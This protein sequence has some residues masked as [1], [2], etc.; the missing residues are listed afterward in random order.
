MGC[1]Q[2]AVGRRS[3]LT[4][5]RTRRLRERF[6]LTFQEERYHTELRTRRHGRD[7]KVSSP[8]ADICRLMELAATTE[9]CP[10][11]LLGGA[12]QSELRIQ[13]L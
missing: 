2:P 12:G 5:S 1:N 7:E 13:N 6:V 8:H 9:D 10:R 11:L 4:I 3:R